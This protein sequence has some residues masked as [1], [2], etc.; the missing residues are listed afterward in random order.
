[1]PT[2]AYPISAVLAVAFLAVGL[3][4]LRPN[5]PLIQE[6]Q[7][8]G[9]PSWACHAVGVCELTGAVL[10]TVSMLDTGHAGASGAVL[11]A[12]IMVGAIATHLRTGDGAA[13]L[14]PSAILLVLLAIDVG[15]IAG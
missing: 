1:M 11:L 2:A 7:R 3:T 10:L 13:K 14:A 5:G 8:F 6:F 15:L 4:K 12:V 9:Y